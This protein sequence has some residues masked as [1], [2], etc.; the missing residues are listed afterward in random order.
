MKEGSTNRRH[1]VGVWSLSLQRLDATLLFF[2]C[3]SVEIY[4]VSVPSANVHGFV[5]LQFGFKKI[6]LNVKTK[7]STRY[8]E[9][10]SYKSVLITNKEKYFVKPSSIKCDGKNDVYANFGAANKSKILAE[11]L[12]KKS[13]SENCC[14]P[15]ARRRCRSESPPPP[16]LTDIST[17]TQT[18]KLRAS[19]PENS[20]KCKK[21]LKCNGYSNKVSEI[22][23]FVFI[24]KF[25]I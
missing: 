16:L 17:I 15:I 6:M 19:R 3:F 9:D 14:F 25:R 13:H 4:Q 18:A 7:S 12:K 11:A 1:W 20:A 10:E 21:L 23:I 5:V 24:S 2:F 8:D 22:L